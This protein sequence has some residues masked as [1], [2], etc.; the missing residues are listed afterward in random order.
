MLLKIRQPRSRAEAAMDGRQSVPHISLR[1]VWKR[2]LPAA[3][4]SE[5]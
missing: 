2:A 5:A 3:W 1:T 4:W